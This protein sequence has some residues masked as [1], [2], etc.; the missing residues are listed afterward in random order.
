MANI[1]DSGFRRARGFCAGRLLYFCFCICFCIMC[2]S[3]NFRS[4]LSTFV[5][6]VHTPILTLLLGFICLTLFFVPDSTILSVIYQPPSAVNRLDAPPFGNFG[7]AVNVWGEELA[8]CRPT[9]LYR[10]GGFFGESGD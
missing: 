10:D 5:H 9:G 6:I 4:T 8:D 1:G 7:A 3:V 2:T